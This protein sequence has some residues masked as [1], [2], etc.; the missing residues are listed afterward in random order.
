M[1]KI[2]TILSIVALLTTGTVYGATKVKKQEVY[3][4]DYFATVYAS[5]KTLLFYKVIDK[6]TVC[7]VMVE[8]KTPFTQ[9][10]CVK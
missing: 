10:D 8:E 1:K 9:M 5:Q 2:I 6:D 7:Y 4:N 3:Q